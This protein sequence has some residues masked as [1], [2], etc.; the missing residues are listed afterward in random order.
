MSTT[1]VELIKAGQSVLWTLFEDGKVVKRAKFNPHTP[2]QVNATARELGVSSDEV[3]EWVSQIGNKTPVRF[4]PA[5]PKTK[6]FEMYTRGIQFLRRAEDLASGPVRELLRYALVDHPA[7]VDTLLDWSD[8]EAACCLDV[9]YHGR[10]P[11]SRLWAEAQAGLNTSPAPIGWHFSRSGGLHLFYVGV[12]DFTAEELAAVAALRWKA[13]D[14]TAVCEL[15]TQVRGP[16]GEEVRWSGRQETNGVLSRWLGTGNLYDEAERE[17]WLA[18]RGLSLEQR[19]DHE[20]CPIDPGPDGGASRQPVRVGEAGVFCHVCEGKGAALGS[21]RPGFAPWSAVLGSPAA[22][23]VGGMVR[24]L[25]HWGHA[26]H[27]LAERLGLT[28][29]IARLAY[30]AALKAYHADKPSFDLIPGVFDSALDPVI[31]VGRAWVNVETGCEYVQRNLIFIVPEMPAVR[32]VG[33]DKKIKAQSGLVGQFTSP[34]VDLADWGYPALQ[35]VIGYRFTER[36]IPDAYYRTDR[37]PFTRA[38]PRIDRAEKKYRPEYLP[39]TRRPPEDE[40]WGRLET[41]FPGLDRNLIRLLLAGAGIAQETRRMSDG[42][43]FLSGSTGA[44]KTSHC[45]IASAVLGAGSGRMRFDTERP[46]TLRQISEAATRSPIVTIDEIFKDATRGRGAMAYNQA[47][48]S[49][50]DLN[51]NTMFQKMYVG[52]V[53]LGRPF[54]LTATEIAFPPQLR[55]EAQIARRVRHYRVEGAKD[56]EPTRAAAGLAEIENLRL[57][58]PK[59]AEACNAILS[60]VTDRWFSAPVSWDEVAEYYGALKVS[61][62]PAFADDKRLLRCYFRLLCGL[63]DEVKPRTL[64][65]LSSDGR[66][67]KK[68]ER[69]SDSDMTQFYTQFANDTQGGWSESRRLTEQDWTRVLGADKVVMYQQKFVGGAVFARFVSGP[70]KKP[71]FVNEQCH[72]PKTI[73]EL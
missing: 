34:G 39:Y 26:K 60:E 12:D 65:A 70:L 3:N 29:P 57:L 24:S 61:H 19:Y 41:I 15:K 16:G 6:Q 8:S 14:P 36:F 10:Q 30:T 31:R 47:V 22:G 50:F 37:I 63:A 68:I 45:S 54:L 11:P 56:W 33:E 25:C 58:S 35:E 69:D 67:W 2:S 1:A 72:D 51:E 17:E 18:E 20:F 9:D 23:P 28:G 27:V 43:L 7:G 48:E 73:E 52:Q 42:I 5:A 66:G 53:P 46:Q 13:T 62:D 55:E 40:Y 71:T 59:I 49:L 32:Y 64:A 44:A 38:A 21:R 4:T